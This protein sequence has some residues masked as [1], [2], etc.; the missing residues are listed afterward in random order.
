MTSNPT[1]QLQ[2]IYFAGID[3]V[4]PYNLISESISVDTDI[5][6]IQNSEKFFQIEELATIHM[7]IR[8]RRKKLL[9]E[10]FG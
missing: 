10:I 5:M 6:T 2:D 7:Q 8:Q 4:T 9:D 1:Q 3:A